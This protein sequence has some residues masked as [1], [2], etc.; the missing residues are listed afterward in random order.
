MAF[1]IILSSFLYLV[2][3]PA[4]ISGILFSLNRRSNFQNA[5]YEKYTIILV[6]STTIF[7]SI[8]QIALA[9]ILV[10]IDTDF[11][12][13]MN[14]AA[15]WMSTGELIAASWTDRWGSYH[16]WTWFTWISLSLIFVK[17]Y[18]KTKGKMSELKE[19]SLFFEILLWGGIIILFL[20]MGQRPYRAAEAGSIPIGMNPS[21]LSIWNFIHPP[22]AFASYTGFFISWTISS[23]FWIKSPDMKSAFSLDLIKF[24]RVITRITWVLTSLVLT[25]GIIWTHEANWGGYW[26]WDGV[27]V[28]SVILWL[29]SGY[30]LH[31]H[32]I[33]S[34]QALYLLLGIIG[35]PL[36]FFAAWLI[37]SNILEGLH[38]YAG[39]P[40]AP[41]FL[42]LIVLTLV[43]L[44]IGW[45]R[46]KWQPL[47]PVRVSNDI[48]KP[49]GFNIGVLSFNFLILGNFSLILLQ[50]A[51][52]LFELDRDFENTYPL[53]NGIGFLGITL[54]LLVDN[55]QH[56]YNSNMVIIGISIIS[57]IFGYLFWV[58]PIDESFSD[59]VTSVES[60]VKLILIITII[61][62]IL[63]MLSSEVN[64]R[65]S[66][67]KITPRR[68][69]S[70]IAMLLVL[71]TII[72]NGAGPSIGT[73]GSKDP[74][75]INIGNSITLPDEMVIT[76]VSADGPVN[77]SRGF[78]V[79]INLSMNKDGKTF[80][81][82]IS[83][84]DQIGYDFSYIQATWIT[85]PSGKEIFFNLQRGDPFRIENNEIVRIHL[86]VEEYYMTSPIWIATILF[87]LI[88]II[89]ANKRNE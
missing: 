13:I 78:I 30:R 49:S 77:T 24:D 53:I 48:A 83:V 7:L 4:F 84:I 35:F 12:I 69:V 23:F 68:L 87:A 39:S 8:S 86:I 2:F 57:F 75:I 63:F 71:L 89:P 59:I 44:I 41:L 32:E 11:Q 40:V 47:S 74:Y 17:F 46:H 6:H 42:G 18:P 31:L 45:I 34:N 67:K 64:K 19:Y 51:N 50:L 72:A 85:Y 54:G 16:L 9:V 79:N 73:R 37:T 52:N 65:K 15:S 36:V 88:P 58:Q 56:K 26:S 29:V 22:L 10:N 3:I 61:F 43:P 80:E 21:L 20:L 76:L 82:T 66:T 81:R 28:V 70:H 55:I 25:L 38:N 1:Q 14:S 60:I 62:T 33:G 27:I 5:K